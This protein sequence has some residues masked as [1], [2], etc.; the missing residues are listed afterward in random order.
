MRE[1]T[2]RNYYFKN[3]NPNFKNSDIKHA[4]EKKEK[5]MKRQPQR[6]D[7]KPLQT[8]TYYNIPNKTETRKSSVISV[9]EPLRD[10]SETLYTL[11]T[12]SSPKKQTTIDVSKVSLSWILTIGRR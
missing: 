3:H 8:T 11:H 2:A 12:R 7:R 9:K 1:K 10:K 4:T 5:P 6:L